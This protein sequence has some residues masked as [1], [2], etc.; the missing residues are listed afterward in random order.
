MELSSDD[1][2][3][4]LEIGCG[5]ATFILGV[6]ASAAVFV[7]RLIPDFIGWG[8]IGI[9]LYLAPTLLVGIGSYLHAAHRK[10]SGFIMLLLGGLFLT[11]MLFVHVFGG[12]FY[13]YGLYGGLAIITPSVTAILTMIASLMAKRVSDNHQ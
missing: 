8:V 4:K 2:V 11:L 7:P 13:L 9:G 12:V 3:R 5:I 1:F 6:A 10:T